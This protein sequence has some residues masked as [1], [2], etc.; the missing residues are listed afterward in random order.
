MI[1]VGS[2]SSQGS[3]PVLWG[4]TED[5]SDQLLLGNKKTFFRGVKL[6]VNHVGLFSY[7]L[8]LRCERVSI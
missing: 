6:V 1:Q 5:A 2:I 3:R 8:A 4:E 7:A